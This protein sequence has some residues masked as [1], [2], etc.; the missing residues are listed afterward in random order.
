MPSK[1]RKQETFE[2]RKQEEC[3]EQKSQQIQ[4]RDASK[5]PEELANANMKM[6][7]KSTR[8]NVDASPGNTYN[9]MMQQETCED[10]R[11]HLRGS[12]QEDDQLGRD[13]QTD[14]QDNWWEGKIQILSLS[15]QLWPTWYILLNLL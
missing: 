2:A 1:A 7:Q 10:V 6:Q 5:S 12:I 11:K 3:P 4:E 9:M 14:L 15:I 8:K 13:A